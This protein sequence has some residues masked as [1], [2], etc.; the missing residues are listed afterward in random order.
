MYRFGEPISLS[1]R[2]PV[3]ENL[4]FRAIDE[5]SYQINPRLAGGVQPVTMH[6]ML[7]ETADG[8]PIDLERHDK[9]LEACFLAVFR[10]DA[11]ND[12]FNR[13]IVAAGADWRMVAALRAYA[14]YLRQLG[15]P[16]GPRYIADTLTSPR[17][18]GARSAGAV[19]PALRS[20][21]QARHQGA[22]TRRKVPSA[23]ASRARWRRCRA[24]TRT[25][26]CACAST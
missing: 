21:A 12:N 10:G 8:A 25:A 16:F 20:G 17:R 14:A 6:D 24:S 23:S 13:L 22:G 9:R 15:A 4:G 11:D 1:E 19:P 18:R 2:V 5:R 7:I 3:L 26:S